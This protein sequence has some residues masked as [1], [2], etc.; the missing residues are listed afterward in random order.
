MPAY[1]DPTPKPISADTIF[2]A[3]ELSGTSWL[4]ALH[5]PD[6]DKVE[7]HRLPAGVAAEVLG[8]IARTKARVTRRLGTTPRVACCYETGRD[9]FWLHRVLEAEGVA[10]HVMDPTSLQV[11]RR[12]RRAKT[13]RLD[14]QALLRALMA[15]LCG[16][17]QVCSMVRPP[18]PEHE[19]ERRLSRERG[20]LL[21]E[22]L[23]LSNRIKGLC[24]AQGIYDYEPLGADR[25]DRL[26]RLATGDGRALPDRLAAE[27]GRQLDCL[28]LVLRHL[29]EVE[30][31]RDARAAQGRG[32]APGG[33]GGGGGGAG[34]GGGGGGG[35]P[36][37]GVWGGEKA[38]PRGPT[39]G[40]G[41]VSSPPPFPTRRDVAAYA[42][43]APSPY[44]SG[45]TSRE[46]GISK[47]GNR[48]ARKALIEL[49]WLWLRHQPES[50]LARWYRD[51]VGTATGRVKRIAIVALARKLLVAIWRYVET[52]LVPAEAAVRTGPDRAI[53]GTWPGRAGMSEV[54]A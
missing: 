48:R 54:G 29:A 9:G 19:D 51:R 17:Q 20:T 2:L 47:A 25:R 6:A 53:I 31:V 24:A 28:E 16:E 12:A 43:L 11:D 35:P 50:A 21:K 41:G 52:G 36:T 40:G 45:G 14:A 1:A 23:R 38:W 10:S 15:W 37:P 30:A 42:G 46:Q 8:L 5:A 34:G 18:S 4:V 32:G 33:G 39:P 7:R 27:I 26:A 49:A 44:A 3:F 22:R 13:D